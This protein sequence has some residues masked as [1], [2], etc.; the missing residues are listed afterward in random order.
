MSRAGDPEWERLAA[1]L[2]RVRSS[3]AQRYGDPLIQITLADRGIRGAVGLPSQ[4]KEIRGLV[5]AVWPGAACRLLALAERR[6]RAGLY[7]DQEPLLVLRRPPGESPE[8]TTQLLPGDP[9]AGLLAVRPGRY[10]VRAPGQAVG[11]VSA[12][13]VFRWG[14]PPP[15]RPLGPP[16]GWDP[17]RVRDSALHFLGAPYVFGAT[18]AG[19]LDC[20][21]LTWRAHLAGG[22]LLPRNSLAQRQVG[23]RVGSTSLRLGDLVCAVYRGPRHTSHVALALGADEVIHACSELNRVRRESLADFRQR[24]RILTVR[25]IPGGDARSQ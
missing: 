8:L 17:E 16:G 22:V 11:W 15:P 20:S 12:Q 4:A 24:Y 2:E 21:G 5:E 3:A 10:L 1:G 7:P 19:G 23:V 9:G 14:P 6:P 25:R 18:G 13:S